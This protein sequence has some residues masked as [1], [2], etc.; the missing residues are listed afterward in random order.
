MD[1]ILV[2]FENLSS[3]NYKMPTVR[4]SAEA[5]SKG[6]LTNALSLPVE[7]RPQTKVYSPSISVFS[8]RLHLSLVVLE[9]FCPL[10]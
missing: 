10:F 3:N 5:L 6:D 4:A 9:S 1:I 2:Y 7:H 8:R